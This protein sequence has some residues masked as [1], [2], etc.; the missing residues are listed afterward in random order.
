MKRALIF[1]VIGV[2]SAGAAWAHWPRTP[3]PDGAVADRIVVLKAERTLRLYDGPQL[4]RS[5]SVSLGREPAG[6]KQQQGDK[7]TPEGAYHIDYRKPDSSYHR[8]L[9]I[10]YP[11]PDQVAAARAK[12]VSPG[13]LIMIHGLPN[14]AGLIGRLHLLADWTIGCIAVTNVEIEEIWRVVP[15]GTPIEIKP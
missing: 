5:Y 3:L 9:H 7:R 13:G 10:S 12:G 1:A 6:P 2:I 14:G 11:R 15:D 8:A 4:L